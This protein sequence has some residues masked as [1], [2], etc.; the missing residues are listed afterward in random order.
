[1]RGAQTARKAE[2]GVVVCA[3]LPGA[4]VRLTSR[5]SGEHVMLDPQTGL[6]VW[7]GPSAPPRGRFDEVNPATGKIT[8]PDPCPGAIWQGRPKPASRGRRTPGARPQCRASS[9]AGDAVCKDSSISA[10]ADVRGPAFRVRDLAVRPGVADGRPEFSPDG[11]QP[12]GGRGIQEDRLRV[13]ACRAERDLHRGERGKPVAGGI[14][15]R[16]YVIVAYLIGEAHALRREM[17]PSCRDEVQARQRRQPLLIPGGQVVDFQL[18]V[19]GEMPRVPAAAGPPPRPP[20]P[21]ICH[22]VR[23]HARPFP[24]GRAGLLPSATS[25][26]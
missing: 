1:M 25:P 14:N 18:A 7:S 24:A 21:V 16:C 22:P 3:A 8:W 9:A 15:D 12:S 2:I 23:C 6:V 13:Y 26:Q 10:H 4:G 11:R 17:K 19:E 20:P 5:Y